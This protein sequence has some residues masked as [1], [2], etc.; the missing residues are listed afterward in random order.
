[1]TEHL[2]RMFIVVI[3][4]RYL[5]SVIKYLPRWTKRKCKVVLT[6]LF[7]FKC[8]Y[9]SIEVYTQL[10]PFLCSVNNLTVCSSGVIICST[11]HS[12]NSRLHL[13]FPYTILACFNTVLRVNSDYLSGQHS[14]IFFVIRMQCVFSEVENIFMNCLISCI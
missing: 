8:V 2:E 1:M 14:E 4:S 9:R 11:F 6:S 13:V 7:V 3:V 5:T 10:R 12:S